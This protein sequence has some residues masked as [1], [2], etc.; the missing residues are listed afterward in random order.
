MVAQFV[1][2]LQK[3][4]S[5]PLLSRKQMLFEVIHPD[6]GSVSKAAIKE[7]LSGTFKTKDEQIAI[8]GMKSKFGGGRS[9]GYALVYDSVDARKAND[10][11]CN[12]RRD[13]LFKDESKKKSRKQLKEMKG[14]MNKVRGTAKARAMNA[15]KA[16]KK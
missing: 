10:T 5:N 2:H 9:S 1:L 12:L 7:K 13:K 3:F 15:G 6:S 11:K 14:R 8:F 4:V 16:K